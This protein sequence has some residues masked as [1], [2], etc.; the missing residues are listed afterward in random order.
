MSASPTALD[1]PTPKR[2]RSPSEVGE[3]AAPGSPSLA[4]RGL[5][6]ADVEDDDGSGSTSEEM[7]HFEDDAMEGELQL[8]WF[9]EEAQ[10]RKIYPDVKKRPAPKRKIKYKCKRGVLLDMSEQVHSMYVKIVRRHRDG[11]RNKKSILKKKHLKD[12]T[13]YKDI[14]QKM[15]GNCQIRVMKPAPITKEAEAPTALGLTLLPSGDTEDFT[16]ASEFLWGA[17]AYDGLETT[18]MTDGWK[19]EDVQVPKPNDDDGDGKGEKQTVQQKAPK[20]V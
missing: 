1:T 17:S 2:R 6:E 8:G 16:S 11:V 18:S 14:W 4:L 3:T 20:T 12:K 9:V 13:R 7:E 19:F 10:F 15:V 5:E